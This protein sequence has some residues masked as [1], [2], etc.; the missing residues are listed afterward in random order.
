MMAYFI[1]RSILLFVT[2]FADISV[3]DVRALKDM[4]IKVPEAVRVGDSVTL[5]C[6][7][8]LEAAALY[9]I[10]WYRYDS[11][12]YRYVPKESPPSRVFVMSHLNVDVS[13]SNSTVVTLTDV[14]RE[15]S[16][17]FKCEVSADAPR[18]HTDIRAAHLLV[19]DV[20]DEGPVLRTEVQEKSIGARIKANC[21]T[22]GSY[23]PMNITWF[24]NDVEVQPKYGIDI[25]NSVERYDA[26]PGLE[27]VRSMI[28]INASLELFKNGKMKIRCLA[29]MF[30]LY[31]KTQESELHDDAPQLALIMV[32][33]TLSSEGIFFSSGPEKQCISNIL[34][35]ILLFYVH[36]HAWLR[37]FQ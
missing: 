35:A 26:L 23:P 8:D 21:T 31:R 22:P 33:T 12:F 29:T 36:L 11:E 28:S 32:P 19:A 20:P 34:I 9:T 14:K 27:T 7:Y 4:Y 18:F 2:L 10:K 5:A 30:T 17:E 25:H 6:D 37:K 24:I 16:G 13:R 1:T 15:T 3:F